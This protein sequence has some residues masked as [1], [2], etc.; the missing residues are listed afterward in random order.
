ML[1]GAERQ[2]RD[3]AK[4][5]EVCDRIITFANISPARSWREKEVH[6]MILVV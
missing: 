2:L 6:E 3:S 1:E 5:S 4:L